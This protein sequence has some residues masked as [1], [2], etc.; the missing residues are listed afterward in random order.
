VWVSGARGFLGG[1][2]S[3]VLTEAGAQ[4]T[5][6]G[7][8]LRTR[9]D[10]RASMQEAAPSV[11][12][13]LGAKVD[14]RRD[15][16]LDGPM[17]EVLYEGSLHVSDC[18]PAEARLVHVGTCEEYGTI[19]APYAEDAAPSPSVSPYAKWKL[20]T[21]REL[22][23]RG[24][25]VVV[26]RPF[27]TYGPGQRPRQ[28]IPAAIRAALAGERFPMTSGEQT[29]EWNYVDDTVAGL[30][31]CGSVAVAPKLV[32]I[33]GGPELSVAAMVR[34][35]FVAAGAPQDRV[36][37]GALLQRSGEVGR[38]FGDS[39][40][41]RNELGH[42]PATTLDDGLVRTVAWWRNAA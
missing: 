23:R 31:R 42:S 29:R 35:I 16:E 1:R 3:D 2:L 41:C 18:L 6:F 20:A 26:A 19:P 37:V 13:H 7:G 38:F 40:R 33:C 12:F 27:L 25:N 30:L 14:V 11:V 4:V 22:L 8:D 10:V 28:L 36:D 34:R 17:R 5:R 15:P 39:T 24:G 9:S 21:T 32:N